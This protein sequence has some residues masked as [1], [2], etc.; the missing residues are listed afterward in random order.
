MY[1]ILTASSDS[2]E[3]RLAFTYFLYHFLKKKD[4]M[5]R[6]RVEIQSQGAQSS[7]RLADREGPITLMSKICS[8]DY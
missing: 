7:D 3:V 5:R 8:P 1:S 6:A 2:Q 4:N